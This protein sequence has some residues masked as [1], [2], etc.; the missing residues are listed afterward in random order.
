MR[1]IARLSTYIRTYGN[2]S[3][4]DDKFL[5]NDDNII[6]TKREAEV[7]KRRLLAKRKAEEDADGEGGA[8]AKMEERPLFGANIPFDVN[9]REI[10]V[11]DEEFKNIARPDPGSKFHLKN[12]INF[13]FRDEE[14]SK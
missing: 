5:D 4:P 7:I 6:E 2:V 14:T 13:E 8:A 1:E 10:K 3:H 11:T 9:F 12:E